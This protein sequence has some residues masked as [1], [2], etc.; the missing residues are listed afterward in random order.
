[1]DKQ[2]K[3]D[4]EIEKCFTGLTNLYINSIL[5][6]VI[7]SVLKNYKGWPPKCHDYAEWTK[8]KS[9]KK[10]KKSKTKTK[11][12]KLSSIRSARY[13]GKYSKKETFF[14]IKHDF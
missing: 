1:M 10:H 11:D 3:I 4:E 6:S 13:S 5:P 7:P 9:N 12:E 8:E 2:Q 14:L